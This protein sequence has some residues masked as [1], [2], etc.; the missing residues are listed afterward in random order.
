GTASIRQLRYTASFANESLVHA[1]RFLLRVRAALRAAC[2][3]T[4]GPLVSTAR[5]AARCLDRLPRL[6]AALRAWRE[7]LVCD[8]AERPSRFRAPETARERA[9]D[10][11]ELRDLCPFRRSRS[12]CARV[13]LVVFPRLGGGS[14]TPARRAFESPIAIACWGDRAPCFPSRICSISS[15][16]NSPACVLADLPC[17]LSR[18]ARSITSSSGMFSPP[19]DFKNSY[20]GTH[21]NP[22]PDGNRMRPFAGCGC[23]RT[24]GMG[25]SV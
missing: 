23:T 7:R 10:G 1:A 4:V 9:L 25:I 8:A 17:L 15:R 14:F 20:G 2:R 12:A 13:R 22:E 5:V 21:R 3:K 24:G 16:T 19:S 18:S 6:R 11:L